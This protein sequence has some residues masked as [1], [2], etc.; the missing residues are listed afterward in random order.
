MVAIAEA[1]DRFC[2]DRRDQ[3]AI[4]SRAERLRLTFGQLGERAAAWE[5]R[6][7]SADALAGSAV[8]VGVG[9]V[10]AFPELFLALRRRGFPM[11]AL[12]A[13]LA[14]EAK[15]ALCR[16]LGLA[17]LLHRDSAL[18]GEPLG[19]DIFRLEVPGAAPCPT[20]AGTALV[21]LTSGSTGEPLGICLTDEALAAGI[22]Q[23]G[24]GM[25]LSPADRVLIAVPLSHSYGFDNGVLSLAVLGTPLVLEAGYY[26]AML[27]AA[28]AEGEVTFFPAVP[29]MV[30]ALAESEWPAGL[31]LGRVISA[32]GPLAPEFA[33]AFRTRSG[34]AV[35]QF[36]G[37]TETGGISFEPTPEAPEAAGTVGRPLPGVEVALDP[38]GTVTVDSAANFFAFLGQEPRSERR[39]TLADRGE[40]AP[41]GRLRLTGRT[42]DLLN[43]G[44]RRISAAAMEAALR[45]LPGVREA[46]VIGVED[47]L[48][49]DRVVA[50]L[51]GAPQP[52][53]SRLPQGLAARDLRY[54]EAL[55]FTGRGKLDR[56]LL[57]S[58][59]AEK[60]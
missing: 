3:L 52:F 16:R 28:L 27:L 53:G 32:G 1:F 34:L 60:P 33:A 21:K 43:V 10:A 14:P 31:A 51:V 49:G 22:A 44:G 54:V 8:A 39:V 59:A 48:R 35:S 58:W 5:R 55:P 50:F 57:R 7:P 20:P 11:A 13:G 38:D 56:C 26:P 29:P 45:A 36:Y 25:D 41:G 23:I 15:L 12:D 17:V 6:L 46:A 37:S 2:H 19:E 47:S 42:A 40:W 24:A 18:G 9:N 30:R 4:W